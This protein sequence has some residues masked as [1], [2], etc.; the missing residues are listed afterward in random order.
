[1]RLLLGVT[2]G[3]AAYKAADLV[4]KAVKAGF[5]V[6]VIMTRAAT[7]LVGPV[8]FEALSGSRVITPD[9]P[10]HPEP[11]R[12]V[13]HIALAKWAQIACIAP[14][15]AATLGR[16]ACGIPDDVL[17]T[18]WLALPAG[19]PNVLCPAMNTEMWDNPIVQR[20]VRWLEETG[21]YHIVPPVSKRLA[22]GDVGAG[23]LAEV[24]DVLEILKLE[25]PWSK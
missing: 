23:A 24:D 2:G 9:S 8:T 21:R 3:I 15:T 16:L 14:L 12:S 7:T 17:S 25:A 10:S 20:N 18:T 13:E 22:C 4:S 11:G 19:V 5:E 1:M 6:R